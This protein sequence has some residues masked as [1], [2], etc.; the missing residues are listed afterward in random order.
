MSRKTRSGFSRLIVA[1]A[2][3][4]SPHSATISMSGS[5]SN[6]LRN[7]SRAKASSSLSNTRMGIAGTDLLEMSSKWNVDFD[8]A[9]SARCILQSQAVVLVIELLQSCARVAQ[10]NAIGRNR[11][12]KARQPQAVVADL[13]PQ[14]VE[15]L[16]RAHANDAGR[17]PWPNAVTD[18]VLHQRLQD[19]VRHQ[20]PQRVAGDVHFHL[21]AVLKARLLNVD[22]LLQDGQLAAQRHFMYAHRVQREAQQIGTMQ[23]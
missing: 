6:R 10:A 17:A 2:D 3:L 1:I 8:D 11:A 12:A 18:R 20:R 13:H 14:L 7:R 4:P 5:S 19:H 15:D 22:V 16:A 9:A 21:Q 23:R